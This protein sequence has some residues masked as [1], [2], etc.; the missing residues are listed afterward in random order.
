MR[1]LPSA[2]WYKAAK[3]FLC[4]GLIEVMWIGPLYNWVVGNVSGALSSRTTEIASISM[5][6]LIGAF[7]AMK[8]LSVAVYAYFFCHIKTEWSD[9]ECVIDAVMLTG[10][11]LAVGIILTHLNVVDLRL[12]LPDEKAYQ[13]VNVFGLNRAP[14]GASASSASRSASAACE[15][16]ERRLDRRL[17]PAADLGRAV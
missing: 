7:Y 15:I 14:M 6:I 8:L 10:G 9:V 2:D 3:A 13:G 5:P 17:C 1:S 16:H 11:I 12:A 4:V